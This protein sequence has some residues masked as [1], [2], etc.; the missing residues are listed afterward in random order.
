M[1][2]S[3]TNYENVNNC[4]VMVTTMNAEKPTYSPLALSQGV[5]L[6]MIQG[7]SM[8]CFALPGNPAETK[9]I[10]SDPIAFHPLT[11][12]EANNVITDVANGTIHMGGKNL[13]LQVASFFTN[14]LITTSI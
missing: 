2:V 4:L 11:D 14:R 13:D 1:K 7:S 5:Q 6:A 12:D 9:V 8:H 10:K 3:V